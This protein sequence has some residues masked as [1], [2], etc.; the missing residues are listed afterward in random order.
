MVYANPVPFSTLFLP[1]FGP[2]MIRLPP[3]PKH[4]IISPLHPLALNK[5]VISISYC[6]IRVFLQPKVALYYKILKYVSGLPTHFKSCN[7]I[8]PRSMLL[9]HPKHRTLTHRL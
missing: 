7:D 3:L 4:L 6:R 8:M 2:E 5:L 9:D 1:G